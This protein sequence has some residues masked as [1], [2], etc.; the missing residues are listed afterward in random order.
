ME[1]PKALAQAL[2]QQISGLRQSD[3]VRDAQALSQSYRMKSGAGERLVTR[4]AQA[5]AYAAARMPATFGAVFCA[6]SEALQ[7]IGRRP[8]TLLDAGAGTGA[9]CWAAEQLLP[10]E[11][12]TCLEREQAMIKMG[13]ALMGKGPSAL[14]SARWIA[15]DLVRDDITQQAELVTAAYVLNE[16][17]EADQRK[18]TE[19]LWAATQT[20]LLLVEPGTPQGF[21]N[22]RKAREMLLVLGAH[23]AAPCPH[24]GE[25]PMAAGDWCHFSCRVARSRLHMALKAGE[26]PYEDE[27][28]AYLAVAREACSPVHAR[29]LRHPMVH[30]GHVNME[31]CAREGLEAATVSR[32]DGPLYKRARDIKAGA[33][34]RESLRD[35]ADPETF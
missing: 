5:A 17:P 20:L 33:G 32:R 18:L 7:S 1:M 24:E 19:K 3:M 9:A 22:L 11:S 16:M 27:K 25:C 6:L 10:L 34:I 13:A 14:K 23:I 8:Q 2:E 12:I 21:S 26:A 30:T 4:D 15:H 31:I 35:G 29:V 28:F